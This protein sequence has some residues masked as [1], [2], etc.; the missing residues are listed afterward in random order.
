M[1]CVG[2]IKPLKTQDT[3]TLDQIIENYLDG[4]EQSSSLLTISESAPT[5]RTKIEMHGAF[6]SSF[7]SDE[8][9][10]LSINTSKCVA[11]ASSLNS[12]NVDPPDS[13]LSKMSAADTTNLQPAPNASDKKDVFW[14]FDN[15]FHHCIV[16]EEKK[17]NQTV[18]Y[19]DRGIET[20]KFACET[21]RY[22]SSA[23][24]SSTSP[25]GGTLSRNMSIVLDE[26]LHHFRN[27]PFLRFQAKAF[28][29]FATQHAYIRKKLTL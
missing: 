7:S 23:D 4:S 17:R 29:Q 27:K 12:L 14:P 13:Y 19:N 3:Y 5:S 28:P 1:Y 24:L 9:I 8:T 18:V 22:A 2:P 11:S 20:L 21:L 26:I 6:E 25:K 16:T 15:T 10:R